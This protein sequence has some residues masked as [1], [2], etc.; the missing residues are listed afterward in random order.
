MAVVRGDARYWLFFAIV[1]V[2]LVLSWGSVGRKTHQ[3]L[4]DDGVVY[5]HTEEPCTPSDSPC[6]AYAR[7]RALILGPT[8]NGYLLRPVGLVSGPLPAIDVEYR[9]INEVVLREVTFDPVGSQWPISPAPDQTH[10]IRFEIQTADESI[11]VV[12]PD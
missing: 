9:D 4:H 12:F 7:D 6:A 5:L 1:A 10:W 3:V 8:I 2:G 11:R